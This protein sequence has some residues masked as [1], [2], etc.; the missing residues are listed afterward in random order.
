VDVEPTRRRT[1]AIV[2]GNLTRSC[3]PGVERAAEEIREHTSSP[4]SLRAIEYEIWSTQ[5]VREFVCATRRGG[6]GRYDIP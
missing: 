3:A 1:F 6:G 2:V 5:R 4:Q